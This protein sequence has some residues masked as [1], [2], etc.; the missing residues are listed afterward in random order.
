MSDASKIEKLGW[1]AI[2]ES[3]PKKSLPDWI[4][5]NSTSNKTCL[6]EDLWRLSIYLFKKR[7]LRAGE[8]WERRPNGSKILTRIDPDNGEKRF[9]LDYQVEEDERVELFC[10]DVEISS[11]AVIIKKAVSIEELDS[12]VFELFYEEVSS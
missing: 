10:V 11:K 6:N 7:E 2:I 1:E 3:Q 9:V 12:S 4:I 8:S 5:K